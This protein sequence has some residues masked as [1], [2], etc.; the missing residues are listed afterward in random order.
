[1]LFIV[2]LRPC[3]LDQGSYFQKGLFLLIFE[4]V[5]GINVRENIAR[6]P[7]TG[8]LTGWNW[9]PGYVPDQA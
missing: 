6:L 8:T 4:Q 3:E 2:L 9:Q 5:R 1:M 7:P